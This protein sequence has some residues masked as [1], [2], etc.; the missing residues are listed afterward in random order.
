VAA[1]YYDVGTPLFAI[2]LGALHVNL[3]VALGL[4]WVAHSGD[5]QAVARGGLAATGKG[6]PTSTHPG[7]DASRGQLK[8]KSAHRST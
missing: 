4:A 7:H 1:R 6:H 5:G 8:S 2:P 3:I